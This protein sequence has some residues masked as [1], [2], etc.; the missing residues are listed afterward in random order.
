M[1]L[2]PRDFAGAHGAVD[3]DGAVNCSIS[4]SDSTSGEF[5]GEPV[6]GLRFARVPWCARTGRCWNPAGLMLARSRAIAAAVASLYAMVDIPP[7]GRLTRTAARDRALVHTDPS[8]HDPY[9]DWEFNDLAVLAARICGARWALVTLLDPAGQCN[10]LVVAWSGSP[11]DELAPLVALATELATEGDAVV[12][13]D[14]RED[15]RFAGHPAVIAGTRRMRFGAGIALV[16]HGGR[17]LGILAVLDREP[18]ELKEDQVLRLQLLARQISTVLLAPQLQQDLD[19]LKSSIRHTS[20]DQHAR[21]TL[22]SIGDGVVTTDPQGHVTFMN[23][24]AEHLT[25][26][27]LADAAGKRLGQVVTLKD[28]DG[29][30]FVV[31]ELDRLG[32]AANPLTARTLLVRRDGHEISI[33]GTFAPILADD[34]T[35]S[36]TVFAFR[37]VT[38]ARRAAAELNHQATHDP[39]TGLANRRA[40]ERR[41]GHALKTAPESGRGHALLYLDLDQFKHVNDSAGHLAGDELLRQL[42]GLLK[43]HLREADTLARLGGDEFGVLLENCTPGHAEMVAEKLRTTLERFQFVWKD[44]SYKLGVS[45]GLVKI[46]DD[47]A[48]LNEILSH[49]DE[50]CY[51]AKARGRN[52]VHVYEPGEHARGQQ[53]SELEWVAEIQAALREDRLFLCSQPIVPLGENDDH[54]HVEVLLR[55]RAAHGAIVPPMAFL[56][57]AERYH[58]T[59]TLDRWV[60]QAVARHLGDNP[61]DRRLHSINLSTA[62]LLDEGFAEFL[63][64]Q[65]RIYGVAAAQFGFEIPERVAIANLNRAIDLISEL[66]ALGCSFA[67]DD[68]GSGMS[69]FGYLRH[70]QVDYLKINGALVQGIVHDPVHHAMVESINRIGHLMNVRTIAEFVEDDAI[71]EAVREM[72]VDCVQGFA[73]ARPGA[74]DHVQA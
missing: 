66:R 42:S 64:A 40:L 41:I 17:R 47:A 26:W 50:A 3:A 49:A 6:D 19:R 2:P 35:A 14:L 38:L 34:R 39:L 57:A 27:S 44:R 48:G 28:E 46:L 58:L 63:C 31:P 74:L 54:G 51:V 65:L 53:H 8:A 22:R 70:L 71:L 9:S 5:R 10:P 61:Q 33:E 55:L 18:H 24:V 62:S 56:P 52:R 69:S 43:Q 32:F 73:V 37:N 20:S 1:H 7:I 59:T 67:I 36:G 15:P 12:V 23:A 11:D 68:F 21:L 45:I 72:G 13:P 4:G 60:V 29:Q 30:N 25:G 16:T